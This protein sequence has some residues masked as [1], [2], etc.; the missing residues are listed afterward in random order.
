MRPYRRDASTLRQR[1]RDLEHQLDLLH[2]AALRGVATAT[3]GA[4]VRAELDALRLRLAATPLSLGARVVAGRTCAARWE[5]LPGGDR[6][7]SCPRCGQNV[8]D[9]AELSVEEADGLLARGDGRRATRVLRR[10]DGTV[11]MRPCR[12]R[13]RWRLAAVLVAAA[14][15]LVVAGPV[16]AS[17]G[18][19]ARGLPL[20][21]R[22]APAGG[23][24]RLAPRLRDRPGCG[25]L[26]V[27]VVPLSLDDAAYFH[28]VSPPA[29]PARSSVRST[30]AARRHRASPRPAR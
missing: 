24:V 22:D 1:A 13:L 6:V 19:A 9:V 2:A 27:R 10:P 15:A 3:P 30:R 21:T 23:A 7:R 20:L 4:A 25:V 11:A 26:P 12:P 8:Y 14:A 29:P 16:R 5:D 28:A 17:G 18:L